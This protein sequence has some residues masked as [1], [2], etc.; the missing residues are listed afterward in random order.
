MDTRFGMWNISSLYRADSLMTDLKK[1]AKYRLHLF[2]V[3]EVRWDKGG[4]ELAWEYAFFY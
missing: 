2:T 4:T 1:L 3:Q